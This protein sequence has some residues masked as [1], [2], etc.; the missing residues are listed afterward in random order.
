MQTALDRGNVFHAFLN[1][2]GF[3][4][5]KDGNRLMK[6]LLKLERR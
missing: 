6:S 5:P 2:Q 1:L 3:T 4:L